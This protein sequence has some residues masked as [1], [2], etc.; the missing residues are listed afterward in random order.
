MKIGGYCLLFLLCLSMQSGAQNKAAFD[1]HEETAADFG[2]GSAATAKRGEWTQSVALRKGAAGVLDRTALENPF[3]AVTLL[4]GGYFTLGTTGGASAEQ[5][6]DYN[7]ITFGHPFALTSFVLLYWDGAWY[8]P[9][10]FFSGGE[11]DL[12]GR[13]DTIRLVCERPGLCRLDFRI[14]QNAVDGRLRLSAALTNLDAAAHEAAVAFQL[15]AALGRS[16]DAALY[17]DGMLIQR[18][19]VLQAGAPL[20]LQERVGATRMGLRAAFDFPGIA[21][22]G[23][24]VENWQPAW[25][26]VH[27]PREAR[28]RQLFD[29][30]LRPEWSRT[31]LQTDGATIAELIMDLPAPDFSGPAFM[32][33]D[34]P[35]GLSIDR[36]ALFPRDL[37]VL[38]QTWN[39]GAT[40]FAYTRI[41]APFA[42]ELIKGSKD[43]WNVYAQGQEFG[44]TTL[45]FLSTEVF[46]ETVVPV[47]I[48]CVAK[49]V[50]I[51]SLTRWV[52]IPAVAMADDGLTVSIDTV[53]LGALPDID[54]Y[55]DIKDDASQVPVIGARAEHLW[56]YENGERIHDFTVAREGFGDVA[57]V[58]VVFVLDVTGSMT[59][60]IAG[61]RDNIIAFA[62][63][64]SGVGISFRLGMVTFGD[65]IRGIFPFTSD[66]LAFQT[67]VG[68]QTASGGGDSPENSLEALYQA[69]IL[70]FR[71][72]AHRVIVWI[73]DANFYEGNS[74]CPHTSTSIVTAMLGQAAVV[75][76]IGGGYVREMYERITTPTG[77]SYF[78]ITGNFKDIL[79]Q[80]SNFNVST[81]YH[82][83]YRTPAPSADPRLVELTVHYSGKGGSASWRSPAPSI[84]TAVA[85]LLCYP[86]PF[87]PSVS[88]R[89]RNVEGGA[90]HLSVTDAAGREVRR[91]LVDGSRGDYQFEWNAGAEG[92]ASGAAASGVYFIRLQLAREG[93]SLLQKTVTVIHAK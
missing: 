13:D 4:R 41:M 7:Q 90:G 8:R 57:A 33:W 93:G 88:I 45:S 65:E 58:D 76:A 1:L 60:E 44:F 70:P 79:L 30:V 19:T 40:P 16:G 72:E 47:T 20:L 64:L 66:V 75:H 82:I 17:A 73:T 83:R 91:Y 10:Q 25:G 2:Q 21:P 23:I 28:P 29:L 81:V 74:R 69:S 52:Y 5:L 84:E 71:Q 38:V 50:T 92:G 86:N 18:D 46:E 35:T 14:V 68:K 34:M 56:L 63:A 61:V 49:G 77:G 89:L 51:D 87:N 9:E 55:F 42:D 53:D 80:I 39:A 85:E 26:P 37:S 32:R 22:Q 36:G 43:Q 78:D 3:T 24:V 67:E 27:D 48:R 11:Q 59:E 6:D 15:D 31:A 62:E 12:Y 54:V